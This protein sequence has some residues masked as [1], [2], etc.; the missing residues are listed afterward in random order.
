MSLLPVYQ[1][2]QATASSTGLRESTWGF[3]IISAL[4]VLAIAWFGG[5]VLLPGFGRQMRSFQRLGLGVLLLSGAL[6]FWLEPLKC[7]N[8][9]PFRIKIAFVALL[10][11][12][13]RF[14]TRF[15]TFFTW[16]LWLAIIFASPW[17]AY[18]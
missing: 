17:I 15:G 11:L 16:T 2:I 8:S 14:R 5:T 10:C 13:P 6:L 9:V 1:W 3:P 7:Y 12:T 4:H 18:F